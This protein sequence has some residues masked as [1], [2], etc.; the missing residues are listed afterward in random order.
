MNRIEQAQDWIALMSQEE[1]KESLK[2]A[3]AKYKEQLK[4]QV[5]AIMK[6]GLTKQQKQLQVNRLFLVTMWLE[7]HPQTEN[8]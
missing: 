4:P 8:Q 5:M 2:E 6:K 7:E 1:M 3:K